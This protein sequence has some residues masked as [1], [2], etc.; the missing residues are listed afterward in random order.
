MRE[1]KTRPFPQDCSYLAE[2]QDSLLEKL[3]S[4]EQ[5]PHA[6]SLQL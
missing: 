1:G 4:W 5:S 6:S 2:Q 3:A